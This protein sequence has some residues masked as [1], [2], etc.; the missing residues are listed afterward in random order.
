MRQFLPLARSAAVAV[1]FLVGLELGLRAGG[2]FDPTE[3][4]DPYLG[5]PGSARLYRPEIGEGDEVLLRT[6]PNRRHIYRD[7]SFPAAKPSDELRV[8]CIGGSSVVLESF[9]SPPGSFPD[10]LE[11]Y[12]SAV[13]PE[14]Q[15]RVVNA[16]G[17]GTG[18]VQNLEV[19]REVL[20][21]APDLLVVYPEGGE[22]NLIPPA[23]GGL[24]AL[25]DEQSP[26]RVWARMH[27]AQLR[28]YAAARESLAALAPADRSSWMRSAFSAIAA[29]AYSRPFGPQTFSD[30]FELK[31]VRPPVLMPQV[32]PAA[33]IERGHG[34]YRRNLERMADL[35]A[36]RGVPLVFVVPQRNAE[37]SFYLRFHIDPAEIRAG[38][39]E[40]WRRGWEQGL[41][42][43]REGR[44]EQAV[45]E[46][47]GVRATYVED[48]DDLL[49]FHLAECH[50]ALGRR[51]QALA[52][53]GRSVRRHPILALLREVAAGKGVPLVDPFDALVATAGGGVP[54][55]ELFIDSVHPY[56]LAS[57]AIA[58]AIVEGL[59]NAR[60]V[61]PW[62]A[63]A[64][65]DL[66]AVEAQCAARVAA[67]TAANTPTHALVFGAIRRGDH[68]EA[69]RLGAAQSREATL[70]NPV[71]LF[72][73]GWALTLAGRMDEAR[74]LFEES[75]ALYVD[76]DAVLPDLSTPESLIEIAFAGDVFA[77]F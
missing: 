45:R 44:H 27:L 9:T 54:G 16:G 10:F 14:R 42:A 61:Q 12:L 23:P 25:A 57:H 56:P 7:L 31:S 53:Y 55:H 60:V 46:L 6:S 73:Y 68:E 37:S 4:P 49:A 39:V 77:F 63:L 58:R 50:A 5:F 2:L 62:T 43:K 20:D 40:A 18:S 28:M 26:A 11:L 24:F 8:F 47:E 71:D 41:A 64:T 66:G 70:A 38:Q 34:R 33:E 75:R 74:A 35:A 21:Y 3:L 22:K 52:E 36:E 51:E 67:S 48:R 32:I 30:M 1:L 17:G 15:V 69:V 29:Y 76:E 65:L 19:L 72:Y 13:V 59:E